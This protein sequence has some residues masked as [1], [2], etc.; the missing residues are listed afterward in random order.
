MAILS[1]DDSTLQEFFQFGTIPTKRCPWA[2]DSRRVQAKLEYLDN[3]H[4]IDDL[5]QPPGNRL[6]LLE[7]KPDGWW[8]IRINDQYRLIFKWDLEDEGPSAVYLDDYH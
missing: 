2:Q 1:F 4:A 5:R 8:S 3:A 6:E 7:P